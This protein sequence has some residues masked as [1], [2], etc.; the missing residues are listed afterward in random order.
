VLACFCAAAQTR[1]PAIALLDPSDA[2][3][4]QNWTKSLGWRVLAPSTKPEA[5][6]DT[7]A[8]DLAAVIQAAVKDSGVDPA[9][10]YLAGR[11]D[12]AAA[13]FY[14]ISRIPD[15]WAAGVALGGGPKPAIDT[16]RLF[17]ANFTNSPVL[18]ISNGPDDEALAKNLEAK[19]LNVEWRNAGGA[20]TASMFEWLARHTHEDFPASVDCETNSPQLARCFWVQM[21]KFD[22]TARNDVLPSS[23]VPGGSGA[24]LDLGEFGYRAGDPG[25]GL[26]VSLLGPKYSGP[27]KMGDRIVALDGRPIENARQFVETMEK[28]DR[29]RPA[30]AMVQ[31]GKEHVRIE[32]RI[33]VP[34]RDAVVTA[35]VQAKHNPEDN[36]I[37]IISR[38]ATEMKVTIPPHWVPATLFWNGLSLQDLKAPGCYVLRTEKELLHAFPCG[39]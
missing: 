9:R 23:L 27:L 2:A 6:I 24:S 18:W 7:R 20:T 22:A 10:V 31:R 33:I 5:N 14:A 38:T 36:S 16:N 12:A 25:P 21:T 30:V 37:E 19:G 29:E 26:L 17:T 32:T 1:T 4:W 35:R 3:D 8:Q 15:L 28:I 11:G 34:R 13:V 39:S